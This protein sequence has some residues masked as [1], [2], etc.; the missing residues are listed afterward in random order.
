MV[1]STRIHSCS[2]KTN[3]RL[4]SS[5]PKHIRLNYVVNNFVDINKVQVEVQ[6]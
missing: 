5:M 1:F 6:F 2:G 3:P 4:F